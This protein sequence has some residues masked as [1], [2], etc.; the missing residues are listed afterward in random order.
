MRTRRRF[1]LAGAR[2]AAGALLA[3]CAVPE[4]EGRA[5]D[6]RRGGAELAVRPPTGA[7]EPGAEPVTPGDRPLGLVAERDPVLHVPPGLVPGRAAPLLVSLHGAGGSAAAGLALL[8]PLADEHGLLVVAPASRGATWD[9]VRDGYGPD[10]DLIGRALETVFAMV[11]VDPERIAVA[12]FS[13]G[14]SYALG[15][16]L[17]N[18]ELFGRIVAFSPGFVPP[19]GRTGRPEV[20][21]SHGDADDVLPVDRTSRRIVPSLEDDGY[22]VTYREFAGGHTVPPEIARAAVDWLGWKT[23]G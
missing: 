9:A 1:L 6:R 16:G 15:L 4:R 23:G 8:Q 20:F 10:A 18:G 22:D 12:G 21:V 19:G 7:P 14:A 5:P 2:L 13:D 3:G 11:P 17:A